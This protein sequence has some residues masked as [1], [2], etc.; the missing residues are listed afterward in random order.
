M[1]LCGNK[2]AANIIRYKVI[3]AANREQFAV[4]TFKR[5]IKIMMR[6]RMVKIRS[7][8]RQCTGFVNL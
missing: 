2:I 1:Q 8:D 4:R 3:Q 5:F 6:K 7:R